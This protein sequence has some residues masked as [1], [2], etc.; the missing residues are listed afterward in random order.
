MTNDDQPQRVTIIPGLCCGEPTIRGMRFRVA[1]ILE[2]IA[3]GAS[4]ADLL[5]SFPCLEDADISA[6]RACQLLRPIE[7]KPGGTNYG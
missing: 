7:E 6:A 1:N 2:A 4:R 3:E 5:E